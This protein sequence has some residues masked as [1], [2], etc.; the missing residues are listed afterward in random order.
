MRRAESA[1]DCLHQGR[2]FAA[3]CSRSRTVC[4]SLNSSSITQE[5][6]A[7]TAGPG[8]GPRWTETAAPDKV[9]LEEVFK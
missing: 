3:S 7:A 5:E 4:Q 6:A 2:Q 8:G 1:A 9:D